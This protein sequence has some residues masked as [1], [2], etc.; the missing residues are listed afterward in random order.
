MNE[1]SLADVAT[2][3]AASVNV[4][5]FVDRLELGQS[6]HA[7][8]ILIDGLGFRLLADHAAFAPFLGART[9]RSMIQSVFPSTTVSA[10]ASLG[11]GVLPGTHGMVGS[12][13]LLPETGAVL[14]PLQWGNVPHPTA[15]QPEPT[16]FEIASEHG[17]RVTTVAPV[18]YE[19]S[20]LTRAALRGAEYRPAEDA[21][22]RI[23]IVSEELRRSERAI[24]YVYWP[25]LDRIG[26]GSGVGSGDWRSALSRAD[27]L[28][29][30]IAGTLGP[31]DIA[32]I[33]AD[34]GMVN[35]DQR[36]SIEAEPELNA[37]IAHIAGEPRM[38]H[39]YTLHDADKVAARW[40]A[41]LGD[42]VAVYTRDQL[43]DEHLLGDV[44]PDLEERIGD[45]VAIARG[46]LGLS[47][48]MDPT[49]SGLIGQHGAMTAEEREIP[50]IVV[51]G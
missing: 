15:V 34:H 21:A 50:A 29:E 11:T 27:A 36:I 12:A 30:A 13:F 22:T 48:L 4:P 10:L 38:R 31:D 44:D 6:R 16:V 19:F 5:G 35:I 26:H 23:S 47:S 17:I 18:A 7:I 3:C 39:L 20:G 28:A 8:I 40:R 42:T 46:T 25:E 33:T 45:V 24:T 9:E 49:V 1:V 14:S 32:V 43:I 41:R 2:S 51:R 37:G